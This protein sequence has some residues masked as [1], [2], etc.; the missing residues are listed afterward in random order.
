MNKLL[1]LI[2]SILC[3]LLIGYFGSVFTSKSVSTWY[4]TL[5]KPFFNPP[6]WI[7]SPVWTILFIMI[8][9]SFYFVWLKNP[10]GKI[11][12]DVLLYSIQ[13]ILNL[14]WSLFFF[15]MRNPTLAFLDIIIL[16][17]FIFIL[18][19]RFRRLSRISSYLLA[20]YFLWVAFASILNFSIV[21]LN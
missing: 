3:P 15:G 20:P 16:L 8:G 19:V 9:L 21:I 2:V 11:L 10:I 12:S 4:P 7:F 18:I 1:K 6:N 5:N 17:I 13:L 14:L